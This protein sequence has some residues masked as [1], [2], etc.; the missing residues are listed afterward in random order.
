MFDMVLT[1]PLDLIAYFEHR[2]IVY[3]KYIIH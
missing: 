3:L 1:A 2:F